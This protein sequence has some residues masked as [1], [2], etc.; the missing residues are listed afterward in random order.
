MLQGFIEKP[1]KGLL[2]TFYTGI[3]R[4]ALILGIIVL[5]FL[6]FYLFFYNKF[7]IFIR[8]NI[9][10]LIIAF[11]VSTILAI[12]TWHKRWYDAMGFLFKKKN[13]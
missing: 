13:N 4:T 5:S 7:E 8:L 9:L 10:L 6:G 11:I 12:A 3:N 1:R 2:V